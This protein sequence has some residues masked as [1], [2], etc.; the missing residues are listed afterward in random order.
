MKT[1]FNVSLA[2]ENANLLWGLAEEMTPN[3]VKITK[4]YTIWRNMKCKVKRSNINLI[5]VLEEHS[6]E[7]RVKAIFKEVMGYNFPEL[8]EA[9]TP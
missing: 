1:K 6:R 3:V 5:E 4:I 2:E 9:T 7:K 8:M